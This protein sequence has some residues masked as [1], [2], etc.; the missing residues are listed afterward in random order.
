MIFKLI[1]L[2]FISVFVKVV[3][4]EVERY[5]FSSLQSNEISII[6]QINKNEDMYSELDYAYMK[7]KVI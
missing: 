2:F 1:I 3:N 6:S 7:E 4:I 5:S